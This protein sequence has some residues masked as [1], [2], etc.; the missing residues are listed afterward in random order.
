MENQ[1]RIGIVGCVGIG[2]T[3]GDAV[4]S[5]EGATLVACADI[6]EENARAFGEEYGCTPYTDHVEMIEDAEL[7][8]VCVCTPSG[9]HSEVAVGAAE[10]GAH[11][12]CEK[13]LDV[14]SERIDAMVTAAREA[15]VVLAG[16][17]QH[18]TFAEHQRAKEAVESGELGQLILGDVAVK[19]RRTQEYYDSG[20]WR[21]TRE[22]D[23]GCL[24][25]QAI[26]YIDLLQWLMGGIESVYAMT[27]TTAHDME[28]EDVSTIAVRFENGAYGSIVATTSAG[29]E[30]TRIELNGTNGSYE[31]GEFD[32]NDGEIDSRPE[33]AEWGT[34][35]R[36]V[37]QD[38]VDAIRENREPMVPAREA[39]KA[40]DVI[41]AAYASSDLGRE[42]KLSEVAELS[43]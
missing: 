29:T 37:V 39:R 26:H 17:F 20:A 41:L 27:D 19:W 40:I 16:V 32:L 33:D 43:D 6:V 30:T 34:G 3:H 9:T 24:M 42:V 11:V 15:D 38:F 1:I 7:D 23:G 36:R 10:A 2:T 31:S 4:T 5:A 13:P 21:G 25:N 12:L 28:M 8:A 22:M 35:H 14:Y 18:R